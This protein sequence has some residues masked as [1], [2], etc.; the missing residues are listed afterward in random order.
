VKSILLKSV[1]ALA[2]ALVSG[3]SF[4]GFDLATSLTGHTDPGAVSDW[5]FG[6]MDTGG[7]FTAF[8]EDAYQAGGVIN[9]WTE[10]G[11]PVPE[12]YPAILQ[13]LTN[14]VLDLGIVKFDPNQVGFHPGLEAVDASYGAIRYTVATSGVYNLAGA[15]NALDTRMGTGGGDGVDVLI[16]LNGANV[17]FDTIGSYLGDPI[18]SFNLTNWVLT[19]NDTVDFLVG[20]RGNSDYDGTGIQ[21]TFS[22][23]ESEPVHTPQ[24][25]SLLMSAIGLIALLLVG[26]HRRP[27]AVAAM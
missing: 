7:T 23:S 4:A 6:K 12:S 15:F 26:R 20:R 27:V 2:A 16:R 3:P 25:T 11:V 24:P 17:L 21:A 9:V 13:N 18:V 8:T 14:S 19:A 5:S 22:P 1:L 10:T